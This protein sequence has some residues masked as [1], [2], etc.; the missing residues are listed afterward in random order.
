G[1]TARPIP[2]PG[3]AWEVGWKILF[4]GFIGAGVCLLVQ[5]WA[6]RYASATRAAL[7]FA[8]EPVFATILAYIFRD[9]RLTPAQWLGAALVLAGIL[10]TELVPG[11]PGRADA[12]RPL[13]PP[14]PDWTGRG[15]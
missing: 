5:A 10:V 12:V 4:L 15:A 7:V 8:L 11:R 2:L 13:A 3:G 14:G 9:E 6:Q 1:E